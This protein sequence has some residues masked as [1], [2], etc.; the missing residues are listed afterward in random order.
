MGPLIYI[1]FISIFTPLLLMML[2]VEKK[3]RLPIVFVVLGMFIAVFS[4]ELNGLLL[5]LLEIEK[6]AST[7]KL[8]PITEELLKAIPILFF[9]LVVSDK[10][11][12]LF[13]ASMA[14]GVGFALLENAYYLLVNYEN[15][16]L[17]SAFVRGFATGLMHGMCTLLVGFGISFVKK[18]RKLFALGTFT[19]LTTAMTYHGIFNL[20]IRSKYPIV[21][22]LL[23]IATYLPFFFWRHVK[24]GSDPQEKEPEDRG[25]E[26]TPS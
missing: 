20:L 22:A 5:K 15:F 14:L 23:P 1:L 25:R 9:A 2:L 10:R 6:E 24:G 8:A 16:S 7:V 18:K 13:T 19:L 26:R 4:S 11:E 12:T 21:G 3:A 17:L